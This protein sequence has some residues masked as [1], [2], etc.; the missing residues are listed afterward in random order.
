[1][2]I[3]ARERAL[4]GANDAAYQLLGLTIVALFPA[5]FWTAVAA[6]V[7]GAIGHPLSIATLAT[8]GAAIATFLFTA[9]LTLFTRSG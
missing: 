7:G 6:A 5:L 2:K 8:I 9:V 1:M 4:T 3:V